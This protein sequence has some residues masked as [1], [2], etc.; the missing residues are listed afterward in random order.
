MPRRRQGESSERL[1]ALA[2]ADL[3]PCCVGAE[4]PGTL[5]AACMRRRLTKEELRSIG[6]MTGMPPAD[7]LPG[8]IATAEAVGRMEMLAARPW[9]GS[10]Q[11]WC[12]GATRMLKVLRGLA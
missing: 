2:S 7:T 1:S 8:N 12:R 3:G 6:R 5:I 4:S 9:C 10:G 11:K